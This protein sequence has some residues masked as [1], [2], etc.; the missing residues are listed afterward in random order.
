MSVAMNTPAD[1]DPQE[2]RR[3]RREVVGLLR[4]HHWD[5]SALGTPLEWPTR[6]QHLVERSFNSPIPNFILCGPQK[7]VIYNGAFAHL[8]GSGHPDNFGKPFEEAFPEAQAAFTISDE[9]FAG[10]PVVAR[11][12]HWPRFSQNEE[13]ERTFDLAL[14]PVTDEKMTVSW[15]QVQVLRID[16]DPDDTLCLNRAKGGSAAERADD[17]HDAL[18]QSEERLRL[19][20]EVAKLSLWDWNI[21]SNEIVWSDE[22]FRMEGYEVGEVQPSF[23]AWA[24]RIHPDDL[25]LTLESMNYARDNHRPYLHE[26]R[27]RRPDG[28]I[29]WSSAAGRFF[30]DEAGQPMR[31]IGIMHDVTQLHAALERR[32]MLL[33]EMQHRTHNLIGLVQSIARKTL[34]RSESSEDFRD[35]FEQRLSALARVQGFFTEIDNGRSVIFIELLRAELAA[36]GVL[37][38]DKGESEKVTLAGPADVVLPPN[39]VQIFAL[40]LHELATNALKYGALRDD[41]RLLVQWS[42]GRAENDVEQVLHVE[43][44]ESGVE[45][46]DRNPC[47]HGGYGL[48]LLKHALPYQLGATTRVEFGTDGI[49]C[50]ISFPVS[51]VRVS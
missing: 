7:L 3:A 34:A 22:H 23:E 11:D 1:H 21:K 49:R 43:W 28:K 26:F 29:V 50:F 31:M 19:A 48:E 25:A 51:E 15:V 10:K 8:C 40:A 36:H 46:V 44:L 9:A 24:N 18:R 13:I 6:L 4:R 30:Y 35:R 16:F 42:V 39:A 33:T 38:D 41:G 17:E 32:D 27:F 5:K 47:S 14:T 2:F 20:T 12:L 37:V 45:I